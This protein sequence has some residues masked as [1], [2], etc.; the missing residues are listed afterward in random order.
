MEVGD[1]PRPP[2]GSLDNWSIADAFRDDGSVEVDVNPEGRARKRYR[3]PRELLKY[4]PDG[5]I[6]RE[7]VRYEGHLASSPVGAKSTDKI[8]TN[9]PPDWDDRTTEKPDIPEDWTDS[10]LPPGADNRGHQ[11]KHR[12]KRGGNFTISDSSD[13][14]I[15]HE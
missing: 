2:E 15:W 14:I 8:N 11:G 9:V 7:P 5:E 6:L 3:D 10:R 12:F 13:E 1:V 4:H